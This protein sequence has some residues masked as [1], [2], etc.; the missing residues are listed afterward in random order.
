MAFILGKRDGCLTKRNYGG[1]AG[2]GNGGNNG[3]ISMPISKYR[4][5]STCL[6][7]GRRVKGV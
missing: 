2:P 7:C 6:S 5:R 1:Y 4:V 3:E